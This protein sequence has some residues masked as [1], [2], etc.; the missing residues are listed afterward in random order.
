VVLDFLLAQPSRSLEI[1][2]SHASTVCFRVLECSAENKQHLDTITELAVEGSPGEP[3]PWRELWGVTARNDGWSMN[4]SI[5]R[6][7]FIYVSLRIRHKPAAY[8]RS[9][10]SH[11]PSPY[12]YYLSLTP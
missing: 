12:I 9:S 6:H 10:L 3:G 1:D 5:V 11:T 8:V 4:D 2:P 7:I